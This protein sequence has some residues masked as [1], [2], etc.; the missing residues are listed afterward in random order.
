LLHPAT[1]NHRAAYLALSWMWISWMWISPVEARPTAGRS[2][3]QPVAA[4][5]THSSGGKVLR[6]T[7]VLGE[8]KTGARRRDSTRKGFE[9]K[10]WGRT[11]FPDR[12]GALTEGGDLEVVSVRET[13]R[14]KIVRLERPGVAANLRGDKVD[15]ISRGRR[16]VTSRI[17]T[18]PDR[19]TSRPTGGTF[20][21]HRK[22]IQGW[23]GPDVQVVDVAIDPGKAAAA[24]LTFMVA[25]EGMASITLERFETAVRDPGKGYLPGGWYP[26]KP[27][28]MSHPAP[29]FKVTSMATA[30]GTRKLVT[31]SLDSTRT[32]T[33]MPLSSLRKL[34]SEAAN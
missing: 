4:S 5:V 34:L 13:K 27:P 14:G 9:V 30:T 20:G 26:M 11:A 1:V 32:P 21:R 18:I 28:E 17:H 16:T 15:V 31:I 25:G 12:S 33:T 29:R 3:K 10:Q 8:S 6:R 7:V 23:R 24:N 2:A 22:K 19:V